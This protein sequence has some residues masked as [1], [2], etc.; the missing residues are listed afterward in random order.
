MA[1]T[2]HSVLELKINQI[3]LKA[4]VTGEMRF[5]GLK[6]ILN[7]VK[8]ITSTSLEG[9]HRILLPTFLLDNGQ[10]ANF[11]PYGKIKIWKLKDQDNKEKFTEL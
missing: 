9:D 1:R 7:D 8:V 6:N 3:R 11:I 10:K 4:V 5:R 2:R